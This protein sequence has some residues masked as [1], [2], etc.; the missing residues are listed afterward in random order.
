MMLKISSFFLG[1][2]YKLL[3]TMD[4]NSKSKSKKLFLYIL[5]PTFMTGLS[6]FTFT[7]LMGFSF[8]V[9]V[10]ATILSAALIFMVDSLA[11]AATM[12]NPRLMRNRYAITFCITIFG[13]IGMDS[14]MF[15]SAIEPVARELHHNRLQVTIDEENAKLDARILSFEMSLND[16]NLKV[17][18][19]ESQYIGEIS[20]TSGTGQKGVGNG[21]ENGRIGRHRS[22]R[23]KRNQSSHL[24]NL[25]VIKYCLSRTWPPQAPLRTEAMF[26][27]LMDNPLALI[28]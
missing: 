13:A 3:S 19:R 27:F 7:G 10:I 22:L 20:G 23:T 9:R 24:R 14:T 11:S 15:H 25:S 16:A 26:L 12:A 4:H 5:I 17:E 18:K 6:I 2:D 1:E 21:S 28:L 8:A